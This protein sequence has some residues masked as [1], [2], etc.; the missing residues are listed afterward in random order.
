MPIMKV[1]P[2]GIWSGDIIALRVGASPNP[3]STHSNH[4]A[5]INK[6][7]TDIG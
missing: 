5:N 2:Y 3:Y 7:H 1:R 6:S 4:H